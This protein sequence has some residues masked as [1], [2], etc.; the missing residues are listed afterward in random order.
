[1]DEMFE[2]KSAARVLSLPGQGTVSMASHTQ[3]WVE[4]G[5][6]G[7]WIKPLYEDAGQGHRTWLMKVDKGAFAEMHTHDEI[8]QIYV[9]EGS[10][11]DQD[12]TYRAG[13]FALRAPG[14]PHTAGSD[15][16]A[17]VLLCYMPQHPKGDGD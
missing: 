10:F 12:T 11:F 9:L 2:N 14:A 8:E 15:E 13:D 4:S 5:T 6:A 16:G 1:M 17:T 7:F 3:D